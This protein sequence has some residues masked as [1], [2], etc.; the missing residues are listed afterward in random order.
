[1]S[2]HAR[3]KVVLSCGPVLISRYCEGE[4][5]SFAGSTARET[6][7]HWETIVGTGTQ[8]AA[9]ETVVGSLT[10]KVQLQTSNSG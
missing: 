4:C 9:A 8:N 6:H 7:K 3:I 1:M 10:H 5:C 2:W